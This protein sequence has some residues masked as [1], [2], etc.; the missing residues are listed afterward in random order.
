MEKQE[1][2]EIESSQEVFQE[3]KINRI[4]GRLFTAHGILYILT[5]FGG[6]ILRRRTL[7]WDYA[8]GHWNVLDEKRSEEMLRTVEKYIGRGV[9]LNLGCGVGTLAA[10]LDYNLIKSYTGVDVS[11]V[12][13]SK[14]K[15]RGD[16]K[17]T[18][19]YSQ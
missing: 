13:I 7:D 14:A 8:L 2:L 12:A 4:F 6:C 18:F 5:R 9:M 19:V 10:S 15:K 11:R 1:H 3:G 17:I 16:E